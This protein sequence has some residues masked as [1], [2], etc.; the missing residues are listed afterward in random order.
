M[1]ITNV[2]NSYSEL[3]AL[4]KAVNLGH[5]S[6]SDIETAFKNSRYI[7]SIYR[8]GRLIGVGRAFGDE[9]DC[10]VIC[11]LAVLPVEQS[12]GI[13]GKLLKNLISQVNHHLRVILYAE[14]GREAFYRKH[15]FHTM[16]TAMMTSERLPLEL[17]RQ[18]GFIE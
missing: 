9:I 1:N 14:P 8:E 15:N 5:R 11:D 17:G 13:G 3:A 4:Y 2:I 6:E 12:K 16:K 18:S 7:A 10:A